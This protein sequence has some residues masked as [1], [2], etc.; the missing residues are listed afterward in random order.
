MTGRS[1][2]TGDGS[3]I[4]L[5]WS[6]RRQC[7]TITDVRTADASACGRGSATILEIRLLTPQIVSEGTIYR[8]VSNIAI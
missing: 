2:A 8:I 3:G 1:R 4:Q 7:V 5:N 6:C